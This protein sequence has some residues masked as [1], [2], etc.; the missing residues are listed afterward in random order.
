[1]RTIILG[2]VLFVAQASGPVPRQATNTGA[3]DS[4]HSEN[5]GNRNQKPPNVPPE[6]TSEKQPPT[7]D[8]NGNRQG[9]KNTE[10]SIRVTEFPAVSVRE[11]GFNWQGWISNVLLFI[12]SLLQIYLLFRT[13]KATEIAANAAKKSSDLAETTMKVIEA[14]GLFLDNVGLVPPGAITP[15]S[16]VAMLV[17][18]FGGSRAKNVRSFVKLIIPEVPECELSPETFAIG[19]GG[20]QIIRFL[21]FKDTLNRETFDK[22]VRGEISVRFSGDITYE[23]VFG[24]RYMLNCRGV[25]DA[26]TGTFAL[27][28]KNPRE[29]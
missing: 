20:T 23:D 28:D 15:D 6:I 22:V 5:K 2:V 3:G 9:D 16:H 7:A 11:N 13:L 8:T 25:L 10:Q 18:N 1:M 4:Q 21:A 26:K 12:V 17:K 19:R 27:G 14:P 29:R 24:E